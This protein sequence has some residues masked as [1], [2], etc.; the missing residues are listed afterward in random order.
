MLHG[1]RR[2]AAFGSAA[3]VA[4]GICLPLATGSA[5]AIAPKA[6]KFND[7]AAL[8]FLRSTLRDVKIGSPIR[9]LHEV[10]TGGIRTTAVTS[11]NW[12]GYADLSSSGSTYRT[13]RA[14]WKQPKVTC[15]ANGSGTSLVAFWVGID[16]FSSKT[17]E[18]DGT[19]AECLG[20]ILLGYADWWEMYPT[21]SV[22]IVNTSV[23]PGDTIIASVVDK[24]GTY[25][26]RVT[27]KT[28][29]AESFSTSQSC[30]TTACANSSAEWVAEAPCCS[31]PN[32]VYPLPQFATW[33]VIGA[34]TT[35][36]ST[37][38]TISK[39]TYDSITMVNASKAILAKPS[40][41][42]ATGS[43]FGIKW[44]ASS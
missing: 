24:G 1:L 14:Q 32:Q 2:F 27:D 23:K 30:G 38:G 7:S 41:L 5:A 11:T 31:A 3:V 13:V 36:G 42:N 44:H 10:T 26:L 37:V 12:S 40:A 34:K 9:G 19:I 43:S 4:A 25:S 17:V 20:K 18:Q 22:Q 21:N 35:S 33:R 39:F 28:N 6:H 29:P 15:P 8:A 16:G